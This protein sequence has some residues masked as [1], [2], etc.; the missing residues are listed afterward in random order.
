[1]V[2]Y[3]YS[4]INIKTRSQMKFEGRIFED[5]INLQEFKEKSNILK[6]FPLLLLHFI[7]I[8]YECKM[9]STT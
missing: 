2:V 1:M 3:L 8:R 4:I 7:A 6:G 5:M 9:D